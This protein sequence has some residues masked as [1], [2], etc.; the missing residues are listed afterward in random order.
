MKHIRLIILALA[1]IAMLP[2][3]GYAEGAGIEWDSLNDEVKRLYDAG[4]YDRAIVVAKE[5]L[6]VAE[7]VGPDHPNVA[8]SLNDLALLYKAQG[9]YAKA[10]PLCKRSLAI[11][12]KARFLSAVVTNWA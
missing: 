4:K 7:N 9:L 3:P 8:P 2:S 6:E 12:E 1:V 5:A 10:E 11:R